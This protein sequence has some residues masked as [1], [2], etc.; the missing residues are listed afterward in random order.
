M[1]SEEIS[2]LDGNQAGGIGARWSDFVTRSVPSSGRAAKQCSYR[3]KDVEWTS[4]QDVRA[5]SPRGR[6]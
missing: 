6:T 5:P 1:R 4:E 3:G 2:S